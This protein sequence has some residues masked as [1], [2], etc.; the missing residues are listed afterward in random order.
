MVTPVVKKKK[1]FQRFLKLTFSF[2]FKRPT[3][4]GDKTLLFNV[5]IKKNIGK[6]R[7]ETYHFHFME[8]LC[9]QK[10]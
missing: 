2:F 7:E 1:F 4:N 8:I 3:K 5:I 9:A 6:F 10:S